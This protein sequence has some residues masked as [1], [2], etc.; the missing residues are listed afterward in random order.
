MSTKGCPQPD[1]PP[2]KRWAILR[3]RTKDLR[4][5]HKSRPPPSPHNL[6]RVGQQER[7]RTNDKCLSALHKPKQLG[8]LSPLSFPLRAPYVLLIGKRKRERKHLDCPSLDDGL[9]ARKA[10]AMSVQ[11]RALQKIASKISEISAHIVAR[12][13]E[14]AT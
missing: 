8:L 6:S 9:T 3:P 2:C 7:R 1:G 12:G 10:Q 13:V 4:S 11:Y 14:V 5:F